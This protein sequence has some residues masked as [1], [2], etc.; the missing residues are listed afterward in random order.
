MEDREEFDVVM[1]ACG[2]DTENMESA[3]D[4]CTYATAYSAWSH[5]QHKIDSVQRRIDRF[6][7]AFNE[8]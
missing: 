5:Q 4:K 6:K 8:L 1:R 2:M 7:Y 3:A